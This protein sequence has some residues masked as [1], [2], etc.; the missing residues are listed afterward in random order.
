MTKANPIEKI[1]VLDFIK[2]LPFFDDFSDEE[3]SEIISKEGIFEKY[4]EEETIIKE[5]EIQYN[6][7]NE[8]VKGCLLTHEGKI[9]HEMTRNIIEGA[10]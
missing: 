4:K 1:S 8:I 6:M 2:S 7:E 5:G 3:K 9:V 10:K